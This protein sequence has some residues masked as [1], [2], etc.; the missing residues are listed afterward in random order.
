MCLDG[1]RISFT[2]TQPIEKALSITAEF[3]GA[4]RMVTLKRLLKERDLLVGATVMEYMRPALVK[5][6]K[7]GGFDF[8]YVEYEHGLMDPANLNDFVI[9]ARDNG[10][11]VVMKTPDLYR[12]LIGKILEAGISGIQLPRTESASDVTRFIELSKYPPEGTRAGVTG[13]AS[14]DYVPLHALD[15]MKKLNEELAIIA[16]V[17]TRA[18][19]E[20]I[21]EIVACPGVD[22]C[23]VGTFDLSIELGTPGELNS[24]VV[25]HAMERICNACQESEVVVGSNGLDPET[26]VE[27]RRL[28][29]RFFEGPSEIS[30][31]RDG[32]R[33]FTQSLES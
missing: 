7:Q 27:L 29:V 6:Y 11:P 28:G 23:Y 1:G 15:H 17:E 20:N 9:C 19:L 12:H 4:V 14:A 10:L 8:V 26:I 2:L 3:D 32:I 18:G 22:V 21:E 24:P 30:L 5:L 13:M 16:H 31:L 25:I 33:S